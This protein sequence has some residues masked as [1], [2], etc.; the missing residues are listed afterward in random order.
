LAIGP[1]TAKPETI[2]APVFQGLSGFTELGKIPNGFELNKSGN[3][4]HGSK[5]IKKPGQRRKI[6]PGL[7]FKQVSCRD[8]GAL[9]IFQAFKKCKS[10][11]RENIL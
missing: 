11:Q 3:A 6:Y 7:N 8:A 2:G 10:G 4:T 5:I 1:N 9:R